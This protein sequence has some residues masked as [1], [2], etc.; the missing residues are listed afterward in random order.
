VYEDIV[1]LE[2]DLIDGSKK[3]KQ[4]LEDTGKQLGNPVTVKTFLKF[5]RGE[6][7]QKD[8]VDIAKEVEQVLGKK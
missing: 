7:I 2:Q 8:V 3:V 5:V 6:G 4:L 1:L